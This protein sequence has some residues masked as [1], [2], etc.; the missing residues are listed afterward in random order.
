M[1][2]TTMPS[3]TI[4]FIH[5]AFVTRHCW[6]HWVARYEAQG[7]TCVAIP[8]PFRDRP[9]AELKADLDNPDLAALTIKDVVNHLARTI[10]AL[11]EK[12]I[13][14][15]HSFGG[16]MTQL[17]VQRD[18]AVAAVAIDSVPPQ[19]VI[20]L[21]GSFIRSLWPAITP[22]KSARH[23]YYMSFKHFQ[24]SFANDLPPAQQKAGYD[25]DIV[26]ESRR[27]ARGGL[28]SAA[29]ID[30]KRRH[31]PLLLIAGEKDHIMPASLNR[32]NYRYYRKSPSVTDFKEFPGR[33]HYTII[34]GPG[35]EEVADYA[36][37]WA[38]KAQAGRPVPG[39]PVS[40]LRQ[41]VGA[42]KG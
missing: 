11:P 17:M 7:Y 28:S 40:D 33:A 13:V 21:A 37:N 9:V 38:V 36:V 10:E 12:P 14:I 42:P 25:A 41:P 32:T 3:T 29:R 18:L 6:D 27:L 1:F 31:A 15:G 24:Y 4:A 23:P 30:F 26:P 2:K 35:W 20:T 5:G 8:F 19:G 34:N 16:L 39:E 22:F